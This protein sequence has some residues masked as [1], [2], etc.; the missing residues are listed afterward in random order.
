MSNEV[1]F[2][3]FPLMV[4]TLYSQSNAKGAQLILVSYHQH[5][6]NRYYKLL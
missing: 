6:H 2:K 1:D 3:G 5:L 4:N